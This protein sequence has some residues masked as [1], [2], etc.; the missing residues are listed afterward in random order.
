MPVKVTTRTTGG[1]KLRAHLRA[2]QSGELQ[3]RYMEAVVDG[4]ER[5][6]G[7]ELRSRVPKVTGD[8]SK[9]FSFRRSGPFSVE[10]RSD[11]P[12]A[13]LTTFKEENRPKALGKS[14]VRELSQEIGKQRLPGIAKRAFR[15]ALRSTT[16]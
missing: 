11:V 6:M 8:L 10:L 7:P 3:R 1:Q 2:I 4:M 12:Y 13:R 5:E 14:T 9:S 15:K 16:R